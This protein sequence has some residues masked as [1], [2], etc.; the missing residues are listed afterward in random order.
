MG[1]YQKL[2][3]PIYTA[4]PIMMKVPKPGP[5]LYVTSKVGSAFK[6]T[7]PKKEI[8]FGDLRQIMQ[9]LVERGYT[10]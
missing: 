9:K 5:Q 3:P 8:S 1:K 7:P 2:G 4:T 6:V 10:P